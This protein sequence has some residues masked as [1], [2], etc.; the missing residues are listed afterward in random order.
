M[1]AEGTVEGATEGTATEEG[2]DKSAKASD[3]K[4]KTTSADKDKSA[5]ASDDKGKSST[6]ETKKK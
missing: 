1:P 6:K 5:K 2:K 4:G 3:D